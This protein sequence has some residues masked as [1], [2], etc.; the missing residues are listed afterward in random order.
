LAALIAPAP[1]QQ[2]PA[3]AQPVFFAPIRRD[4]SSRPTYREFEGGLRLKVAIRQA[5]I[6]VRCSA[7]RLASRRVLRVHRGFKKQNQW[8]QRYR[9]TSNISLRCR[10]GQ[11]KHSRREFYD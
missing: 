4:H 11:C 10:R 5:T 7:K 9:G 8:N 6:I 2:K 1:I 3:A